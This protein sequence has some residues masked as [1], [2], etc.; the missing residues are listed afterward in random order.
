MAPRF[1]DALRRG[2]E[3]LRRET[4]SGVVPAPSVVI[5]FELLHRDGVS[6]KASGSVFPT[7]S[8]E[9]FG[10]GGF[11]RV[12]GYDHPGPTFSRDRLHDLL[13]GLPGRWLFTNRLTTALEGLSS[14]GGSVAVA[15]LDVDRFKTINDSLG[16]DAGDELL[17]AIVERLRR[18]GPGRGPLGPTR[19][20]RVPGPLRG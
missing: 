2:V 3:A 17:V 18:G 7:G 9:H 6:L 16:H 11:I 14:T 12:A 10:I 20:R 4:A 19:R 8:G 13:T 1:V 5:E 15:V